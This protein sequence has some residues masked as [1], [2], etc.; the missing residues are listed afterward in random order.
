MTAA[1]LVIA[2]RDPAMFRRL[3]AALP[4]DARILAHIDARADAEPF[5]VGCQLVTFLRERL[6]PNWG[7]W[8]LVEVA[9]R[10]LEAALGD[11]SV[12]R[13][14]LLSGQ[15]YPILAPSAL[16][17]W[18]AKPLDRLQI[19]SAPNIEW[20]KDAWR[21]ERRWSGSGFRNPDSLFTNVSTSLTRHFGARRDPAAA[22]AGRDLY[23]G[24]EWWSFTRPTAEYAIYTIR[25]DATLTQYFSH[26]LCPDEAFWHTVVA[27]H[28]GVATLACGPTYTK[29]EVGAHPTPLTSEDLIRETHRGRFA[30]ARKFTSEQA[31]LLDFVDHLRQAQPSKP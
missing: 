12:T 2:H 13:C 14:T 11:A 18:Q 25:N 17:T 19:V 29:W 8:T 27:N 5:K 20:G 31:E 7:S 3:A 30:F 15:C 26:T 10:L 24:A 21:F 28:V 9:A 1:Y 4:E 6:S 22:L 16:A 23:A